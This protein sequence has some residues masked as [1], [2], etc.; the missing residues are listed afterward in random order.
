M[1]VVTKSKV[2]G[3]ILAIPIIFFGLENS[4]SVY[5]F[6]IVMLSVG[7]PHGSVDHIIAFINP[8]AR[9]FNNKFL[10]YLTYLSLITFN[11]ILWIISPF[12]GL[13]VFLIISCY[14]FGE[15]QVIGYNPTD[16]KLLNFVIGANILLSLF[17]NNIVELQEILYIIPEFSNFD[18]SSFDSVFFLLIAVAVLMLSILNFE[19]KRKVPLYAEI[20]ILYMVFF[21]TDL[22]TSFALYFGFCHSLPMLMLEFEEFKNDNFIKFYLKTL[23]FTILSIIFGFLIYQFNNDLLTSDN[24]ILFVFIIISSLTL[25]HVFIMR[26]FVK[27]K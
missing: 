14:H 8:K 1:N 7:I 12:I 25:P 5:L 11:I 10:F 19:I 15:T 16:N 24:L 23:P 21:H 13:F 20:T 17:L 4:Y 2:A 6:L 27:D 26:D 22:L 3:L 18:L 9:K